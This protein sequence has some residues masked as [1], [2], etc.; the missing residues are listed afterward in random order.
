M[1]I[2]NLTAKA[3][4]KTIDHTLLKPEATPEQIRQLCSEAKEFGFASVCI[5]PAYVELAVQELRG[6]GVKVC[7]VIGFPLGATTSSVKAYEAGEAARAGALEVDTVLNVGAL[8]AKNLDLVR[9]DIAGVVNAVRKANSEAEVKVIL[10]T[11]LLSN[12]EKVTACRLAQAAGAHFV[13]TSTGFSTAGATAGD[14]RLMRNTVGQAMQIK[15]SGGIRDWQTA[16]TLLEA[17]ADRLGASAGLA[18]INGFL[19][20]KN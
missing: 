9:E 11:C 2:V 8:K 18:I 12:E 5:N 7:T 16:R 19:E 6:T 1:D 3:L 15:A 10:E 20:N 13:K 14:I 17:G 4:A